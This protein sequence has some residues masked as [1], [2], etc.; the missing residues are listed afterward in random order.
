MPDEIPTSALAACAL[1]HTRSPTPTPVSLAAGALEITMDTN[2]LAEIVSG[3]QN[4]TFAQQV[5]ADI[6]AGSIEG[7]REENRLL[8]VGRRLLI[9][10]LTRI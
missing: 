1:A 5:R 3:Y 9:S 4:D 7:R 2:L 6:Q 10:N 8:Y